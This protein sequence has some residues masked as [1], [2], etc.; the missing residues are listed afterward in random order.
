MARMHEQADHAVCL[1]AKIIWTLVLEF[2]MNLFDGRIGKAP[3]G[4]VALDSTDS[5][6]QA[7]VMIQIYLAE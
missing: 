4:F 6:H 1:E 3:C 2:N 5:L 7:L